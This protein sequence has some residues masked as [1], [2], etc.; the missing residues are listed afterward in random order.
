MTRG[1]IQEY[2]EAVRGRYH[3]ATKKEKGRI[4]DEFTRVIGCHRKAAIR[5]LRLRNQPG[6]SKKGG[7]P[8]Q[9][10]STVASALK[11]AWGASDR[12]CSKRLHPFLPELVRV[13]RR[14]GEEAMTGEVGAKLFRMSP[15]TI[16]RLLRPYRQVGGRRGFTIRSLG[17]CLRALSP[18]VPLLTGRRIDQASWR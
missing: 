8:R 3:R 11:I 6:A 1:S 10:G 18:S 16:D 4:L 14:Y 5:L 13:L 17:A 2:T 7:R 15:A 9:Y 12:L